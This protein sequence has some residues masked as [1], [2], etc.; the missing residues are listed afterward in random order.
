MEIKDRVNKYKED[1]IKGIRQLVAVRSVQEEAKEGMPFGEG[2]AKALNVALKLGESLGFK[3]VNLDNYAGYI[4][5]GEGDD[6]I[7]ILCHVDVVPEGKDWVHA[8]FGGEIVDEKIYGRGVCD[9]KGPAVMALYAMKI[10]KDMGIP[11]KKRFR[12]V[13]GAN[14]ESGFKCV[15][16]YKKV[17]GGFSMGFSPDAEFP[18]IFGEK[19]IYNAAIRSLANGD[20]PLKIVELNGGEA[21]NVVAPLC[22]CKLEGRKELLNEIEEK[23]QIFAVE[24]HL[25]CTTNIDENQL[26]LELQGI[27]AHASTPALGVNAITHML[28]FLGTIIDHSSFINAFNRLIGTDHSGESCNIKCSDIYGE[29]TLNV[30]LISL[31]EN[32]ISATLDIRYPITVEFETYAQSFQQQCNQAG[33]EF[34]VESNK[35]PL[36]VDPDSPLVKT[37]YSSYSEITGDFE[38]KPFTI[39]GGTYSRAFENVV[40][41]GVEFPGEANRVHM[42]DEVISID[43]MLLATEIYVDAIMKLNEL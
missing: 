37:L 23:F 43:K 6:V 41:F 7:G 8:P 27:S 24:S 39:G 9:D 38:N 12:L 33:L 32:L 25:K 1:M 29:L 15:E 42:S 31:K 35:T 14:E 26:A 11:L 2:P 22:I 36:F 4:E 3:T 16:H 40:A 5:M 10:I 30:G 34:L 20:K 13:L 19:G 28:K 21:K 18:L 17:E